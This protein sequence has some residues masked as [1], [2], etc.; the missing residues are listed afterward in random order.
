MQRDH[1]SKLP[2]DPSKE[3][4]IARMNAASTSPVCAFSEHTKE[5]VRLARFALENYYANLASQHK[6]REQRYELLEQQMVVRVLA[7]AHLS[8]L[9]VSYEL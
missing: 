6:E 3:S 5:K 8:S 1:S 7:L 4:L 9:L 2:L